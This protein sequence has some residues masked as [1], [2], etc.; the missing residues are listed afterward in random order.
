MFAGQ[1][2]ARFFTRVLE[3]TPERDMRAGWED[4]W[5]S[6]FLVQRSGQRRSARENHLSRGKPGQERIVRFAP[7]PDATMPPCL[8][9]LH[10]GNSHRDS[11]GNCGSPVV[12][13]LTI[14][15]LSMR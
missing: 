3:D 8:L 12:A 2:L 7:V 14:A 6:G 5:I 15:I 11:S 13:G 10:P 1:E 9:S 4:E